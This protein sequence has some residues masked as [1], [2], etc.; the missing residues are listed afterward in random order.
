V[1]KSKTVRWVRLVTK[2]VEDFGSKT[3]TERPLEESGQRSRCKD[4]ID[5]D[6]SVIRYEGVEWI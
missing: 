5:M 6:H 2:L 3:S 1:I 4:N